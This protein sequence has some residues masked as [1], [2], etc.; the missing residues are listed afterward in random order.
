MGFSRGRIYVMKHFPEQYLVL[1]P[2]DHDR[3][4]V[5]DRTIINNRGRLLQLCAMVGAEAW[6]NSALGVPRAAADRG[7][8]CPCLD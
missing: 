3:Q 2:N 4:H 1:F 6:I 5:L 7:D 8:S